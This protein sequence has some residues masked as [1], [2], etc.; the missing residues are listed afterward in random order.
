MPSKLLLDPYAKAIN[1]P[2]RW[3][4]ALFGY[5]IGDPGE[6]LTADDRDSAAYLPKSVVVDGAFS[7]GTTG[8]RESHGTSR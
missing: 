2:V 7:W 4:E 3:N 8:R 1:G 5:R 6:D